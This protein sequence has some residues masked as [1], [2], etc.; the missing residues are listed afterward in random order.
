MGAIVSCVR[1]PQPVQPH[2]LTTSQIES[3]FRAIGAVLMGIVHAVAT[4]IFVV[5]DGVLALFDIIVGCLTCQRGGMGHGR[6]WSGRRARR[7]GGSRNR[8]IV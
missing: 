6:G 7:R 1:P 4:I 2:P 3:I 5:V 8:A